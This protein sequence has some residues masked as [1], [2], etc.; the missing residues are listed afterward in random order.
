M[1]EAAGWAEFEVRGRKTELAPA[2]VAVNDLTGNEP[3]PSQ[4]FRR[5]HDPPG[6]KCGA[7]CAGRD[8]PPFVF[9]R[10]RDI[11]S[12]A[13]PCALLGE[14]RWRAGA[15]FSEV[16]VK[17]DGRAADSKGTYKNLADKILRQGR[18]KRGVEIHHD[19]AVEAGRRQ[20][21]QLVAIAGKLE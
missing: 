17:A 8:R 6:R 14:K 4:K 9:K 19:S 18:R 5:L 3:G 12:E 15:V 10:R 7:H 13:K 20:K 16:K 21:A 2:L 1:L 11:D